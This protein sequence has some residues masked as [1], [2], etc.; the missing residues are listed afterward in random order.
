MPCPRT[1]V[2]GQ[3]S[4]PDRSGGERTNHEATVPQKRK[5]DISHI[6]PLVRCIFEYH[7]SMNFWRKFQS[8]RLS[9]VGQ[10]KLLKFFFIYRSFTKDSYFTT[11]MDAM[12]TSQA[13]WDTFAALDTEANKT[14]LH[15]NIAVTFTTEPSRTYPPQQNCWFGMTISTHSIWASRWKYAKRPPVNLL[16]RHCSGGEIVVSFT[17]FYCIWH[18]PCQS[19][20]LRPQ[21]SHKPFLLLNAIKPCKKVL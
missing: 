10:K 21:R 19:I 8:N 20:S 17:L 11:L 16:V 7:L 14:C 12:K 15:F 3:D 2:P 4:N 6:G 9:P 1:R 5:Q 18:R 13:G